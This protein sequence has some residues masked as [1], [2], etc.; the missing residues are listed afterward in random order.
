[1]KYP[2]WLKKYRGEAFGALICL[3]LGMASGLSATASDYHWYSLL[4]HPSFAPPKGIFGPVWTILYCMMG[5]VLTRL[6]RQRTTNPWP[7]KILLGH[8]ILNFAW[9]SLFFHYHRIDLAF[10]DLL[11][12]W[13]SLV[14]LVV[15]IKKDRFLLTI[16]LIYGGWISF[17]LILNGWFYLFNLPV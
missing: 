17:A 16:L 13:M 5:V 2:E 8:L 15:L 12:L 9:S 10:Y 3:A 7:I 1:M 6:W 4:N 11:C 14:V